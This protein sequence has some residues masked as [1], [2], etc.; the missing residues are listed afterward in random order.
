MPRALAVFVLAAVAVGCSGPPPD[1]NQQS[2]TT[3]RPDPSSATPRGPVTSGESASLAPIFTVPRRNRYLQLTVTEAGFDPAG[4]AAPPDQRYY[5]VGLRGNGVSASSDF[6][7]E[8]EHFVF[9]QNDRGCISTPVPNPT[10]LKRPFGPTAVF[11]ARD[12]TEGQLTFLVPADTQR[13]RVLIAPVSADDLVVPAG[14]DFT[15]RWP[16]PIKT[17]EDGSTLRVLVLPPLAAPATLG[18]PPAG[19]EYVVLDFVIENLKDTQGIEFQTSQQL[20]MINF[21]GG[22][23]Q[24]SAATQQIGCRLDDGDVIPPGQFRRFL[25]AYELP[26]GAAKK[27]QY[28]GFEVDETAVDLQ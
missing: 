27:L 17:I 2:S 9:A 1:K 3:A 7:L 11:T 24:S 18:T 23:V 28:R 15:P 4:P 5:T 22:F 16:A 26:V 12:P 21:A 25:A 10:W 6:A 14:E 13:V 20:R 19:R 8:F